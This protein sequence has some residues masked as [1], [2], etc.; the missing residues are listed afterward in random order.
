[1]PTGPS[2]GETIVPIPDYQKFMSPLLQYLSDGQTR[3]GQQQGTWLADHF[4]LTESQREERLP[5]GKMTTL[6]SRAGWAATYLVNAGLLEQPSRGH[7]RI[8]PRGLE[9][10]E[11]SK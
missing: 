4:Q 5:S 2:V 8:T 9:A 11:D 10:L 1:M 7:L 3:S 6:G